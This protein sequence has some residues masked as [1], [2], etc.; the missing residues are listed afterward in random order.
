MSITPGRLLD[1][2]GVGDPVAVAQE[3]FEILTEEVFKVVPTYQSGS[4]NTLIGP[5]TSGDHA[6]D[7]LWKD[8]WNGEW[9]CMV[10][11]TPGTWRQEKPAIRPGE[12]NSGTIP[13]GYQIE[14]STDN[15]RRKWHVGGYVWEPVSSAYSFSRITGFTGGGSTNLD[16]ISTTSL[17]VGSTASFTVGF[18]RY[19]YRLRVGTDAELSPFIIRPDDYNASTNA[20][21]WERLWRSEY[22]ADISRDITGL[23]GSTAADL[24]GIP[25]T[26]LT[27]GSIV[28]FLISGALVCYRLRTGTDATA[29]PTVIRPVDF[30][31]VTNPKVW[32]RL[33]NVSTPG[34]VMIGNNNL[35]E[36]ST[37]ATKR[38]SARSNID[39][40]WSDDA[41]GALSA[42]GP[43]GGLRF[44][45]TAGFQLTGTTGLNLSTGDFSISAVVQ[46]DNYAPSTTP[47]IIATHSTGNNRVTLTLDSSGRVVLTFI[48]GSG[49][50]TAYNLAPDVTLV[51]GEAYVITVTCSRSGNAVLYVNGTNDRDRSGSGPSTSISG[52]SAVDIGSGNANAWAAGSATVGVIYALRV[53]NRALSAADVLTLTKLGLVIF[54]DQWGSM[55]NLID[56]STNNGGFE[57]AGGGGADTLGSWTEGTAG[58]STVTRDTVTFNSGAAAC[59]FTIDSSG[60]L[61]SIT[62]SS[63]LSVGKKYLVTFYAK[64]DS[65]PGSTSISSDSDSSQNAVLTTSF[66]QYTWLITAASTAFSLKRGNSTANRSIWID[67]VVVRPVGAILNPDL[68]EADPSQSTI[69]VDKSTNSNDGTLTAVPNVNQISRKGQINAGSL[70]VGASSKLKKIITATAALN[71][72]SIAANTTSD[73][74]ITVTGAAVGDSV[75]LGPPSA[76]E[77]GITYT[78]FVSATNTVTVR[79]SNVT[80]GAIDPA[81]ATFRATVFQF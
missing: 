51:D 19:L 25:T 47:T 42:R 66:A 48:D 75:S 17:A 14:D 70:T 45:G 63:L 5:P 68:A 43:R 35:S 34:D 56:G 81:S 31:S 49:V 27:A 78:A 38:S 65:Q 6:L 30:Q 50:S 41:R 73:L 32:E 29:S 4:P 71:F 10:A 20:K 61:A 80:T 46:L 37:S 53:F 44:I 23:T 13:V 64:V 40:L 7:E 76:P 79:A 62:I 36:V 59:K 74:T 15:Y 2:Q 58:S 39:V 12:P 18:S 57:T 3:N 21:V 33:I 16:G 72:P 54:S 26:S 67:D 11:G 77:S 9:R 69:A 1:I 28:W 52:S 22:P 24:N 8:V 60:S 55:T